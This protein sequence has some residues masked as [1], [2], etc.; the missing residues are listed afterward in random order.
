MRSYVWL[1]DRNLFGFDLSGHWKG[2]TGQ[3]EYNAWEIDFSESGQ[4]SQKPEGWYIQAGYFI[5]GINLEP[6]VRYEEYDQDPN[7]NDKK[8]KAWTVGANW[9]LKGHSLKISANRIHT[10]FE[11][12]ANGMLEKDDGKDNFQLQVQIHF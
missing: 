10:K 7:L 4:K 1:E 5:K 6:A 8:E 11:K 12:E 2:I 3:F 9:Y